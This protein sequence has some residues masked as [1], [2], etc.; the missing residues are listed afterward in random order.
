MT[1]QRPTHR[2]VRGVHYR[3]MWAD[4]EP[5][6][7]VALTIKAGDVHKVFPALTYFEALRL[8]FLFNAHGAIVPFERISLETSVL[9]KAISAIRRQGVEVVNVKE[10][11]F[12]LPAAALE[13]V[14]SKIDGA[15]KE[16]A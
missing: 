9:N 11:G 5:A 6:K 13:F 4:A 7:P 3:P 8:S 12:M 14:R 15:K 1:Y 16:S 2:N 10:R